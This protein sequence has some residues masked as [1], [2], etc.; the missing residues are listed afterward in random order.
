MKEGSGEKLRRGVCGKARWDKGLR[1]MGWVKGV[2]W[3]GKL[4]GKWGEM[5]RGVGVWRGLGSKWDKGLTERF[6]RSGER[7][8]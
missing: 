3:R 6:H 2:V 8:D 5:G 1:E 7:G 4:D